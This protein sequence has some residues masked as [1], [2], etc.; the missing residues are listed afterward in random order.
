MKFQID[1]ENKTIKI[2][3][4]INAKE[5][6]DKLQKMFP[7]REWEKYELLF[8]VINNWNS[9]VIIDRWTN[10]YPWC[11]PWGTY[12]SNAV[13]N[14]IDSNLSYSTENKNNIYCVEY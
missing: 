8:E 12:S 9:P 11:T 6:F 14:V 13:G 7:K 4:K 3:E 1:T 5:L 2:E 10:P